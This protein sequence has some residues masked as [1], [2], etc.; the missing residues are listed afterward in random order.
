[1]CPARE[2]N[3]LVFDVAVTVQRVGAGVKRVSVV[4]ESDLSGRTAS[5]AS[6]ADRGAKMSRRISDVDAQ[7]VRR[8]VDRGRRVAADKVPVEVERHQESLHL[9]SLPVHRDAYGRRVARPI[10]RVARLVS[11]YRIS[12]AGQ[13]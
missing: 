4:G 8:A 11:D 5:R 9:A 1:M 3:N 13:Q 2:L 10:V 12:Y 6:R 7:Q